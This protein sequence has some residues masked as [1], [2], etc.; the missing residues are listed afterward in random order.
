MYKPMYTLYMALHIADPEVSRLVG[1]LAKLEGTTKTEALRRLLQQTLQE[2]ERRK[3][4]Q[5]FHALATEIIAE[6][7]R[8]KIKP[9]SKREMDELWGDI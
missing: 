5:S 7:R 1:D 6:G 2:R 3:K 9:V 8:L 4:Q